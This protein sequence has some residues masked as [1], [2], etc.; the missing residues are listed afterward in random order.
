MEIAANYF[1]PGAVWM[2]QHTGGKTTEYVYDR[3]MMPEVGGL[4]AVHALLN[5]ETGKCAQ[6]TEKWLREGEIPTHGYWIPK[7]PAPEDAI[8]A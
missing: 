1:A 3:Q 6:V 2:F 8:A 5:P 4:A 7:T